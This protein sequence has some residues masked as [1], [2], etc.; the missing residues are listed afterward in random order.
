MEWNDDLSLGNDQLDDEDKEIIQL[1]KQLLEDREYY[2]GQDIKFA[3]LL[4]S[5]RVKITNHFVDE[6]RLMEHNGCPIPKLIEHTNDHVLILSN[7]AETHFLPKGEILNHTIPR[8]SEK[9]VSHMITM[10]HD[11]IPYLAK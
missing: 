6:E 3:R 1:I 2:V 8:L 9:L 4:A 5:L 7:L 11:C 10:D